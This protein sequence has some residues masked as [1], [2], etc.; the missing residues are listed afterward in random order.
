VEPRE[1]GAAKAGKKGASAT[2]SKGG[3]GKGA[4]ESSKA[5]I[6]ELKALREVGE[7]AK[8]W[9]AAC[10]QERLHPTAFLRACVSSVLKSEVRL[11]LR[12]RSRSSDADVCR[13]MQAYAVVCRR[14]QA[15]ADVC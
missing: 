8:S 12:R 13:R 14:M 1:L 4:I 15:Y 9:Q 11:T 3:S 2:K 10:S 6:K 7:K 5:S